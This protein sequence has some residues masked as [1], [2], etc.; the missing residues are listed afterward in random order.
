MNTI[1]CAI[2]FITQMMEAGCCF[3]E[4]LTYAEDYFNLSWSAICKISVEFGE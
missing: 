3:N 2:E 4:A 1:D